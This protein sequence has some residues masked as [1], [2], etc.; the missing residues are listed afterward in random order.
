VL[1]GRGAPVVIDEFQRAP[2][3]LLAVKARVDRARIP[4]GFVLTGSTRFLTVPQLS[5]SLA[6]R[7]T[8]FELWPF[9]AGELY[10][11]RERFVDRVLA[12]DPPMDWSPSQPAPDYLGLACQ[13]GFPVVVSRTSPRS[14][15]RWFDGYVT[16]I[17]QRDVLDV[18]RVRRAPD[19]LRV[20]RLAAARTSAVLNVTGLA[21]DAGGFP[22]STTT[23]Y[24]ALLESVYLLHRVPAWST[25]L[26]SKV[27]RHPKLHVSDSG[28][29]AHLLGLDAAGARERSAAA[30]G[31]LLE[32]Y[33]V[34]EIKKQLGWADERPEMFHFRDRNGT[35]VD[36]VLETR[37]GRVAAIEVKAGTR[38]DAP[39]L[40]GLE[41]LR[42][43]LGGKFLMGIVLYTG[44]F[45]QKRSDR[46]F[47]L[48]MEA[49][50]RA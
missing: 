12:G 43:R 35:E 16:T 27:A 30:A 40:R 1:T 5:E 22:V 8:L 19:L 48:P 25:N 49:L 9:S 18:T 44:S 14:R 3:I 45:M 21:Q 42:D 20:L 37:D 7:A 28:L 2:E 39:D 11:R 15:A 31:P 46:L 10:G 38:V 17:T 6:G 13:G 24:L 4:G 32:T 33:V 23:E 41:L 34:N 36:I 26:T 50:W 29:C 47:A